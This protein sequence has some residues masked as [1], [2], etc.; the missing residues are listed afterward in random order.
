MWGFYFLEEKIINIK[1]VLDKG[2]KIL[3]E[4][5]IDESGMKVRMLLSYL[6]D[7]SKEYV[8]VHID[9]DVDKKVEGLFFENIDKIKEGYP[10]QYITKN[11]AFMD[12]D[13]YVDENVL[14][15]Q[16]DT[17]ILVY[18]VLKVIK[19]KANMKILDLCT[20]SGAI[21]VSLANKNKNQ[22]YFASDISGKAIEIAKKNAEK[23]GEDI[24]FIKSD[25]FEN[26]ENQKFDIIVSNPPYIERNTIKLLSKE[27]QM[28]PVIALDGGVDGLDFYRKII[29]KSKNYLSEN[30]MLLLEIG[31][32]QKEDVEKLFLENDYKNIEC[33]KDLGNNDR[34]VKG[35]I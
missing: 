5:N 29:S 14:I 1:E 2:K 9:S 7:V 25:L 33:I 26:I 22:K 13:F 21:V 23:I 10:I 18:E 32:N 35:N 27:V 17:E 8:M 3:D 6:L 16:P 30:G 19:D 28:E 24:V 11:Q 20:G 31:Y 12:I 15:P 4:K 34:V